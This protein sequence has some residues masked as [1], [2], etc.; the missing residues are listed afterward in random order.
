MALTPVKLT[1]SIV[2]NPLVVSS[3]TT[4]IDAINLM[5]GIRSFGGNNE[6]TGD[7]RMDDLHTDVQLQ[8]CCVVVEE[9]GQ[10]VGMFAE[11]DVV[12]LSAHWTASP[13]E[14]PLLVRQVMTQPVVTMYESAFTDIFDAVSLLQQHQLCHLPVLDDRDRLVGVVTY[15][16]LHRID[17]SIALEPATIDQQ[18]EQE[19]PNC[20][21]VKQENQRLEERL[22]FLLEASPAVIFTCAPTEDYAISFVSNNVHRLVGYAPAKFLSD[23][24]FWAKQLHPEDAPRVFATLPQLFERGYLSYEYRFLDQ[25][26]CYKWLRAE[27][28]LLRDPR[29]LP[30]EIVGC[31]TDISERKQAE[32]TIQ[33]QL[34]REPLLREISRRIRQSLDLQTIFD[35]ACEQ[36]RQVI[37][38][39]RV[40]IFKFHPDANFDDGEFV[41]ESVVAGFPSALTI[42]VKDNCFGSNYA[43]LYAKGRFSVVEDI[44]Q[45]GL[46]ACHTDILSQFKV[47][48][49]LVMPLNCGED[50]WGLL[51][52]HQCDAPRQWQQSEIDFIHQLANQLAIGIQQAKLFDQLQQELIERQ[53]AQ[54]QLTERN[55]QLAVSNEGLA[56]AT[57]LKDE[58]LANMSHELR[59][60]LNAILGMTEGLQEQVFGSI[61]ELQLKSLQ[62]VERS[63]FHLLELIN[64]ILDV[65]KIESGHIELNCT[66][67]AVAPLCKSSL[68]FIKQ[69]AMQRRIQLEMKM[70]LNLPDL[71]VD[72]RRI[73][74]VLINLLNN[75]VKFT[76][77]GGRIT[78]EISPQQR[79]NHLGTDVVHT[80]LQIAVIDTGIGVAPKDIHKLFQPFIQIDSA[81]NRKYQGTGLGLALVKRIVELHGGQ[82]G[83][84]SEVGSGSC[85]TIELP[86][87]VCAP[88]SPELE[89]HQPES[90]IE[91]S[92]S[93]QGKSSVILLAE[94]NE[95]NISMLFS[96][97]S[98]KG[99]SL[100]VANNGHEA[101][102]LANSHAPD[103]I[104]MDIQMPGMDGLEAIQKIRQYS[105]LTLVP[106]I[107][108]TALAMSG[109]RERCLKAGANEYLSKPVKL[110]HLLTTIQQFLAN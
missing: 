6:R 22:Q 59:T 83:L 17:R 109:D 102:S 105:Q 76:P 90:G 73:R 12:R 104:L 28:R 108:L 33:Q 41:A 70:P 11:R 54:Q 81:L 80:F 23:A 30:T 38:A 29:N 37:Q 79:Q 48:A 15:E 61:N 43:S 56:R 24:S 91:P 58:F 110:Q 63:G 18:L 92:Q 96:Y 82:V 69:Q 72:E 101:I 67:T 57:R 14:N 45:N 86:C 46:T 32:Q 7:V 34:E 97:L 49:N 62:T 93:A 9:D 21:Q 40:G 99:Y 71:L 74:Q 65:A 5:N 1:S 47:R 31:L 55:Q 107:A 103:L 25:A 88:L 42:R 39:D 27:L 77:E 36:I 51:C 16:S 60:P 35:T 89:T 100:I 4:V 78:L 75:A 2:R 53:Q 68:A 3:D 44:Y 26:G 64:D 98:A 19:L 87:I 66:P 20:Q 106:I 95:A 85:F 10:V 8:S 52:I 94:D 50:L 84:T 13:T